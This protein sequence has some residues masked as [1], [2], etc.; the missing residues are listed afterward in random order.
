MRFGLKAENAFS[1]DPAAMALAED[2]VEHG[3]AFKRECVDEIR[4]VRSILTPY[5]RRP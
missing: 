5:Y 4:N 2:I 3:P 1:D